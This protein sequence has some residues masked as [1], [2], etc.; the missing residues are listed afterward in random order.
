[1]WICG[2]GAVAA[3]VA[4]FIGKVEVLAH[5]RPKITKNHACFISLFVVVVVVVVVVVHFSLRSYI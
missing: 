5:E 2:C 1:M 4:A 3:Y